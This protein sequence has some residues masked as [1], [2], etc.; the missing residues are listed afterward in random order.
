[1]AR[2]KTNKSAKIR[3]YLSANPS[4][5]PS[6]II[7]ALKEKGVKVG[8]SLVSQ[9]KYGQMKGKNGRRKKRGRPAARSVNGQRVDFTQLV[10]A[11]TLADKMGG[12]ERA[13]QA[14]DLLA[15][16]T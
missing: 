15:K 2:R 11:K 8:A 10:E 7:E 3:E 9:V 6:K 13:R 1:M 4:A 12:V 16:L 5:T 14:L